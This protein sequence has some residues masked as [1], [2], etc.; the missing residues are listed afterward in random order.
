MQ[1]NILTTSQKKAIILRPMLPWQV[2]C[3]LMA[4][5]PRV[6]AWGGTGGQNRVHIEFSLFFFRT[7]SPH[8]YTH[9]L[10]VCD[11]EPRT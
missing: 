4:S 5:K 11:L 6:H 8:T 9:T 7:V 1:V 3:H 10:H 2:S